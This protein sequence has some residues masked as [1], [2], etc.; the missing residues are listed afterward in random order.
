MTWAGP[1]ERMMM[2]AIRSHDF[3]GSLARKGYT[4]L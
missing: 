2:I 1:P 3:A 4:V